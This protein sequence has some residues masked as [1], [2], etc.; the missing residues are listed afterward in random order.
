MKEKEPIESKDKKK[1]KDKDKKE[2][3][4]KSKD[5]EKKD[6]KSKQSSVSE[7]TLELGGKSIRSSK[8]SPPTP[9]LLILKIF[10]A[11][12]QP[13]FGVSL[14]LSVQ[15]NRCHDSVPLPLVVR[16]CIDYLQ[17]HGLSNDQI[18]KVDAVKSRVQH[19]KAIYNNRESNSLDDF[20]VTTA[21]SLLKL[22]FK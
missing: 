2:K 6:K 9:A 7:E 1:D 11:D 10:A 14:G 18:Y 21:C 15:R 8:F 20:D 22:F 5:K 13:I 3:K 19:L 4:E 12:A 17:E 16:D